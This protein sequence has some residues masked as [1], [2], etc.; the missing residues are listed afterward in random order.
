[1]VI[2]NTAQGEIVGLMHRRVTR[3]ERCP[4]LRHEAVGHLWFISARQR[5]ENVTIPLGAGHGIMAIGIS[6]DNLIAIAHRNIRH[7][8]SVTGDAAL[9]VV[10]ATAQHVTKQQCR[11]QQYG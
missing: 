10:G 4:K 8:I 7:S 2:I 11:G 5:V 9:H 3:V 6:H 1:M